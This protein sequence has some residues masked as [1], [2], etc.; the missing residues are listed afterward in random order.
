VLDVATGKAAL[1]GARNAQFPDVGPHGETVYES[2]AYVANLNLL[3]VDD[4]RR[5]PQPLWPSARYSNYP[6]FSP[7]GQ[8]LVF[9]SNRDNVASI[10]VGT[11]GGDM[12][13]LPLPADYVFAQPHWSHDGRA[14]YAVRGSVDATDTT[15][16]AVRID[17]QSGRIDVLAAMGDQVGDV[18]E[19]DDGQSLYFGVASGPLMQLWR[20]PLAEPAKR[21]RLPLPLVDAFDLNGSTLAYSE[22]RV[23]DITVC[24][25]PALVC[26]PAGLPRMAKER[27]GWALA[28]N[29]VWVGDTDEVRGELLRFDL[30]RHEVTARLPHAPS[31]IGPNLA[32]A[33]DQ[34]RA[35]ISRAERPAIDL[36]LAPAG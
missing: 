35:V 19:T 29:A 34:R 8:R 9:L 3:D 4:P 10:F 24:A 1:A 13:R 18:R 7:D 5:P 17:L 2:A 36:M 11:P 15:Q 16:R 14:L 21:E 33:P 32:I 31:A 25:L 30:R 27:M 28:A 23:R 26:A 22:P 12:H 20:A 6:Q